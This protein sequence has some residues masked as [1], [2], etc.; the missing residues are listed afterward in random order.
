MKKTI[1]QLI[2]EFILPLVC[3]LAWAA[4]DW[5]VLP[6]D[7]RALP[8]AVTTF[9]AAFFFVSWM[10][11]QIFRVRKQQKV[12]DKLHGIENNIRGLISELK[13]VETDVI[14]NTTGG[15]SVCYL[16]SGIAQSGTTG[17]SNLQSIG[18]YALY[19]VRVEICDLERFQREVANG[20]PVSNHRPVFT[21]P[22]V[23]PGVSYPLNY[24]FQEDPLSPN[25]R[26]FNLFYFARNGYFTQLVR[27]KKIG[28]MWFTAI[29]VLNGGPQPAYEWIQEGYP[30]EENG[31][32]KWD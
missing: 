5:Y 31:T 26:S 24:Q 17:M 13:E 1:I 32:V 19:D 25:N 22:I 4:Y 14:G 6:L 23:L 21:F 10:S 18:K 15:N 12:E 27:M 29:R 7:K 11:G 3:A 20:G 2:Q 8:H 28:K 9:G 16:H 30:V